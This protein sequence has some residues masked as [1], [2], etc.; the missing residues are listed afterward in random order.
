MFQDID[1]DFLAFSGHKMCAPTG[2]GVLYLRQEL[3]DNIEPTNI[4]GGTIIDVDEGAY[5]L[6][7]GHTRFE[8]G[9]PAIAEA[10]GLG[11]VVEYLN[12]IGIHNIVNHE[13]KLTTKLFKDLEQIPG[14]T[15]YGTDAKNKIALICFNIDGMQPREVS[16]ALD[17]SARIMVRAGH[18]CALPLIKSIAGKTGTVRASAYFYNTK[19]DIDMLTRQVEDIAKHHIIVL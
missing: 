15:I 13:R 18:H 4:G 11:V 5:E 6:E 19:D 3:L 16:V 14:V 8:A 9:T 7:K 2:C 10:L 1:C 17:K 12:T